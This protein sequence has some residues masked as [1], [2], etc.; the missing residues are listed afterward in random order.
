MKI[1]KTAITNGAAI[2]PVDIISYEVGSWPVL[3]WINAPDKH[4]LMPGRMIR[5]D[6]VSLRKSHSR[7]PWDY[8]PLDYVSDDVLVGAVVTTKSGPFELLDQPKDVMRDM[9]N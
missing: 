8:N 4:R 5:T 1:V 2:L 7:L 6:R 3:Q 9:E